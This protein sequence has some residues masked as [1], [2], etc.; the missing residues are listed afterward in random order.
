[1]KFLFVDKIVNFVVLNKHSCPPEV[2][3]LNISKSKAV[4]SGLW[5]R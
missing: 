2:A 4:L 5:C 3:F 1:M